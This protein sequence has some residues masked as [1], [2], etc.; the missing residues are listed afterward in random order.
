MRINRVLKKNSDLQ[1]VT[2][3]DLGFGNFFSDHMLVREWA[4]DAWGDAT[5]RPRAALEVE[6]TALGIQYGQSVFEGLKAYRGT[7]DGIARLFRPDRNAARLEASCFRLCIPPISPKE[8]VECIT[9]IVSVESCW[10]P[11]HRGHALYLRPLVFANE[12]HLAV[13]PSSRYLF[14]ITAAPVAPYFSSSSPGLRLK[15]EA[16][17][18]R[19]AMGGTGASK[20]SGNYAPTLQPMA[21]ASQDGFDQILWLDAQEHAFAEEAGQMNVFFRIGDEVVTPELSGTIL[22]GITRESVITL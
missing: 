6:P 16:R 9:E 4:D 13:R 5:I 21:S 15:A 20:T 12:G 2:G 22:P 3:Q 1:S 17:F 7:R 11:E 19:A 8:F 14:V 18:T 10:I